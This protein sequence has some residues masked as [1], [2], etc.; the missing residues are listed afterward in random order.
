MR[1][2]RLNVAG[3]LVETAHTKVVIADRELV[4]VG[5][6]EIGA[7]RSLRIG[8]LGCLCKGAWSNTGRTFR[9]SVE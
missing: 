2:Y 6:G 3:M 9:H 8:R 7:I 1:R 5:S 4:Y